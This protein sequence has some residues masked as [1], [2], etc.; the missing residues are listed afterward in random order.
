MPV[1]RPPPDGRGRT[2]RSG[3]DTNITSDRCHDQA[4]GSRKTVAAGSDT[5]RFLAGRE[6][7]LGQHRR[8][9]RD[10]EVA[11]IEL[12]E[13]LGSAED[14]HAW[15]AAALLALDERWAS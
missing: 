9:H 2:R 13:D 8:L 5:V 4:T 7:I 12:V 15:L 14:A 3:P 1:R 11:V 10:P 6:R